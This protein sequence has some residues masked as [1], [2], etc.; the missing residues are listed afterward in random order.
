MYYS[1]PHRLEGNKVILEDLKI[2][3]GWSEIVGYFE[4]AGGKKLSVSTVRRWTV[5]YKLPTFRMGRFVCARRSDL[6][7]WVDEQARRGS[8]LRD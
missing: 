6:Q 2:L 5:K 1:F 7:R 3:R 8:E 4:S